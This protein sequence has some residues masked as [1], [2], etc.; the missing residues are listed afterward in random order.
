MEHHFIN[1]KTWADLRKS[2][3]VFLRAILEAARHLLKV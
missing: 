3:T 1:L 2:G